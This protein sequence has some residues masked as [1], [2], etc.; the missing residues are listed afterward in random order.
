MLIPPRNEHA[1]A[2][3]GCACRLTPHDLH[4]GSA[5]TLLTVLVLCDTCRAHDAAAQQLTDL[6]QA[7]LAL[8]EGLRADQVRHAKLQAALAAQG[9]QD[10]NW[11]QAEQLPSGKPQSK[12]YCISLGCKTAFPAA[13]CQKSGGGAAAIHI[14]QQ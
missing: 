13:L 6:H 14:S 8:Q 7:A 3:I 9:H 4:V 1:A 5:S 11:Q 2:L 12:V 10:S